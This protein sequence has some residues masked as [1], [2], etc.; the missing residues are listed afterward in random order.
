MGGVISGTPSTTT[1]TMTTV[2][3][4]ATDSVGSTTTSVTFPMVSASGLYDANGF[5]KAYPHTHLNGTLYDNNGYNSVGYN[6]S[7]FNAANNYN[8]AYD[9]TISGGGGP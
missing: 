1:A 6:S 3:L 7:G 4:T 8:K 9:T 2:V 5:L